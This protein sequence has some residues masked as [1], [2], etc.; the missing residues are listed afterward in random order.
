MK[1]LNKKSVKIIAATAMCIFTLFS[2][3]SASVAWFQAIIQ[4]N[5]DSNTFAVEDLAGK[6]KQLTFHELANNGKTIS[7]EEEACSFKFNKNP[8]GSIAY[9]WDTKQFSYL[10]LTSISL[11]AYETLDRYQPVL[12][13][14]ELQEEYTALEQ[15]EVAISAIVDEAEGKGFIGQRDENT[16]APVYDLSD[17]SIYETKSGANYYWMSSIIRFF[18]KSFDASSFA[19]FSSATTYNLTLGDMSKQSHF[20]EIDD[21]TETSVFNNNVNIF[22]SAASSSVQYIAIIVDYYPDAIEFIYSTF[23]GDSTLESAEYD[24]QLRYTCDWKMEVR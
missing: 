15:G 1:K 18:S 7:T 13:L 8:F 21:S 22:E 12:L 9:N 2:V 11:N 10:G 4:R 5:V 14:I 19:T 20:V 3:F 6:F 23:L 17:S 16:N 24:Y